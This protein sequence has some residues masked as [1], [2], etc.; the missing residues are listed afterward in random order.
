MKKNFLLTL[1]LW[2]VVT[3]A[4]DVDLFI[5]EGQQL[6]ARYATQLQSELQ[7]SLQQNGPVAAISHCQRVVPQLKAEYDSR[8]Q[9]GRT[10]LKVRNP[11]NAADAWEQKGLNAFVRRLQQGESYTDMEYHEIVELDGQA[12][13]RYME[14]IPTRPV[15]L[16]CHGKTLAEP[17]AQKIKQLYPQDQ[18]TGFE[19]GDLRG[20]F[21]LI[22]RLD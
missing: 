22:R 16:T 19:I 2:P 10:A 13:F 6:I 3:Q 12:V 21:T 15:C 11:L 20:A 14:A 9:I 1:W 18:A 8:W 7:Q 4:V 5:V 17:V